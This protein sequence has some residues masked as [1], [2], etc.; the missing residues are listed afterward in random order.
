MGKCVGVISRLSEHFDE[1]GIL[2]TSNRHC[3]A[4]AKK[5]LDTVVKELVNKT[6][7]TQTQGRK[8]SVC[9]EK[10]IFKKVLKLDMK[11]WVKKHTKL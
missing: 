1:I 6:V 2:R 7:F 11:D 10:C 3:V 8:H 5:D 4:S 9:G